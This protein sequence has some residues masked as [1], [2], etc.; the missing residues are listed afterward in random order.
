M[1]DIRKKLAEVRKVTGD[2]FSAKK[3]YD[4]RK[5]LSRRRIKTIEKYYD[6]LI[7]L[8]RVPHKE[9][10][11]RKGEKSE[12]FSYTGQTSYPRFDRAF[13]PILDPEIKTAYV[14]DKNRPKG[15]RFVVVNKSNGQT[16]YH[17]PAE[18]FLA[19]QDE[20]LEA[21]GLE[22][23][24]YFEDVLREYADDAQLFLINANSA[25]MWGSS[26]QHSSI[27]SK[28][29][30]LFRNYGSD[31]F[32]R[33]DPNSSHFSNWFNGVTAF[34][35]AAD[36]YPLIRERYLHNEKRKEERHI[37]TD[38]NIRVLKSGDIGWFEKGRLIRTL[39]YP[40]K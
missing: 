32:N 28:I 30:E 2:K 37:Q 27:A 39:P 12:A 26:G 25:Y 10:V 38:A 9:Y 4:L 33:N 3:G 5:P 11:P 6:A 21:E 16:F 7:E 35:R 8:T 36:A 22:P 18:T 20:D 14:L 19:V 24:D 31:N 1:R 23:E 17:I 15:S 29:A 34:T 13:I 40:K